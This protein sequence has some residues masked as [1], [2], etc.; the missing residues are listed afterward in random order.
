MNW[1]EKHLNWTWIFGLLAFYLFQVVVGFG[2]GYV[3][4]SS[5]ANMTQTELDTLG[6]GIWLLAII[7][8]Y[9]PITAWVLRKKGRSLAWILLSGFFFLPLWIGNKRQ[10]IVTQGT[11]AQG[12]FCY[13][14]GTR[15]NAGMTFCPNCGRKLA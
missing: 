14:C 1:F 11:S 12:N 5:V 9:V 8:V 15:L 3:N 6:Y 13:N 10:S 4:S 7:A 2:Y